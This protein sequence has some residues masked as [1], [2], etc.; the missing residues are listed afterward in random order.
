LREAIRSERLRPGTRLPS[1][2]TL[3]V[4]LGIARNTVADAYGQLVAE[5]WLASRSGSGTW[6]AERTTP[7]QVP[8]TP[9]GQGVG[10]FRYDLRPGTP[11]LAAF[12]RSAWLTAARRV[13]ST[14][15]Y[16][17]LG[18]SDPRGLLPLRTALADYLSRARGVAVAPDGIVVC[19]GFTQGLEL[20]CE[21]LR[22]RGAACLA[23][24]AY[25]QDLS[26]RIAEAKGLATMTLP[27]DAGG[28]AV[29][30]LGDTEAVLLTPAHQFPL[31]V[32][33]DPLRRR[34]I[35]EWASHTGALIVEDDY[36]G[37]F[38]YDR[39][40]VGALQALAPEQVVYAGTA[41]KSLAPGLRLGWLV[42]PT[43][44]VEEVA[45]AK[46]RLGRLSSSLDQLVLAE[47][48]AS[49]AYDRHVRRSRL[50]YR[51]RRDRLTATLRRDVPEVR[52]TGI[53]A[54]LHA[55]VEL[56]DGDSEDDIVARAATHGLA[57]DG[58]SRYRL[59]Q[60]PHS[61]ALVLGYATPP[62]HA[63]TTALAR[64]A[65]VLTSQPQAS[66]VERIG[67]HVGTPSDERVLP[68]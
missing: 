9:A 63:Y 30:Q 21:V 47:L 29:D 10:R 31:G 38:R 56:P 4:D 1:S 24:E 68:W 5:G 11:N 6:V 51:W 50:T 61:P 40:P 14:S 35:V 17:V 59:G 23:V 49:G 26:Q 33:L 18:Y 46:A 15:S 58:L 55:L 57:L 45:A 52:V 60:Q 19:A 25:G 27:V 41:S 16:D 2:R 28:A 54:G 64:L 20:L 3:A 65:A 66:E 34:H 7:V 36:D 43:H 22:G 67:P 44:L 62:D 53:D 42:L 48:I 13:L 12:P 37:E 39:R 32:P 8:A